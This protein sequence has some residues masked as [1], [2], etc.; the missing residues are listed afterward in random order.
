MLSEKTFMRIYMA[1]AIYDAAVTFPFATPWTYQAYSG[2]LQKLHNWLGVSGVWPQALLPDTFFASLMGSLVLVWSFARIRLREP[3]L[4][5][6]DGFGRFL[7]SAWMIYG[8]ANGMSLLLVAFLAVEISF[9]VL[10]WLPYRKS[11]A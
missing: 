10:Q 9:G 3:L 6:F 5:R 4:A 1:S 11:Q 2:L 8:L 7:F